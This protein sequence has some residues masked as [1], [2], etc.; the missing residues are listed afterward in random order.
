[1][2][3]VATAAA[4]AGTAT[5]GIFAPSS[6]LMYPVIS[7]GPSDR[8]VA[9][10]FDDGPHPDSTP[11]ILDALG[12]CGVRAAFFVVGQHAERWPDLVRR[13]DAL[14]RERGASVLDAP[15]SGGPHGAK[16]RRLAIPGDVSVI[17]YDDREIAQFMRPPLTTMVLPHHEMGLQAAGREQSWPER[18]TKIVLD[19]ALT[20]LAR[21][22]GLIAPEPS[23]GASRLRHWG[24]EGY[25][26]SLDA[27]R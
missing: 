17:G 27:W 19:L 16:S 11:E 3:G 7:H 23:P 12:D 10:T 24:E 20:R 4:A 6:S 5:Y 21:H 26:P 2:A 22:Y 15:V 18:A 25:K 14:F 1:M 8:G 13:M 9:L